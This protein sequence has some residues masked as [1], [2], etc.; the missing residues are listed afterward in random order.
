MRDYSELYERL[1]L[2]KN[3]GKIYETLLRYGE[4]SAASI[5][6][7]SRIHRRNVYDTLARLVEKGLVT[8]IV[9]SGD[10]TYQAAHPR[11]FAEMVREQEKAL[12]DSMPSLLRLYNA[13]PHDSEVCIYRGIE[14]VKDYMRDILQVKK[15]VYTIGG[16]GAWLD[17][18]IRP[19]GLKFIAE[20]RKRGIR[21]HVLFDHALKG[22]GHEIIGK[23]GPHC[24]YMPREYA[25][26]A[27]VEVYGDRVLILSNS[28]GSFDDEMSMVVITDARIAEGFRKWFAALWKSCK[29]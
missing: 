20:A 14:G 2:A 5:A 16:K 17:R 7:R 25:A 22:S 15:D 23:M 21:F 24:R 4:R 13:K 12:T 27:A 29:R 6:E 9:N 8:E 26:P 11:K 10:R 19:Y 28:Y 1:G 18:R 3:E